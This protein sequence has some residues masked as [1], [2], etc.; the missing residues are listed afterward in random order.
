MYMVG[1]MGPE[2]VMMNGGEKVFTAAETAAILA[3]ANS[4]VSA[5]A[6]SAQAVGSGGNET[7]VD[8]TVNYTINGGT[9]ESELR[10]VLEKQNDNL[11]DLILETVR[12]ANV[13]SARRNYV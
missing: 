4:P 12:E 3:S 2:L 10:S 11:R 13:D 9:S 8:L 7:K 1:E 5:D 6:L